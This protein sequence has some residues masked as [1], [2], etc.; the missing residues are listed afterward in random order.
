MCWATD[1]TAEELA[2]AIEHNDAARL[3]NDPLVIALDERVPKGLQINL[4]VLV[5]QVRRL[6]GHRAEIAPYYDVAQ[7]Q[8][9]AY[10]VPYFDAVRDL[11]DAVACNGAGRVIGNL[12]GRAFALGDHAAL[13]DA[14][15]TDRVMVT[16]NLFSW[17]ADEGR[18]LLIVDPNTAA[19]EIVERGIKIIDTDD[20]DLARQLARAS[21]GPRVVFN[22][23][24]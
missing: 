19:R 21:K 24:N 7:P 1:W 3:A 14:A 13:R 5:A 22:E 23:R 12:T 17:F 2:R 15:W 6:P 18:S 9:P 8:E 4:G 11:S 16:G 10:V 20:R